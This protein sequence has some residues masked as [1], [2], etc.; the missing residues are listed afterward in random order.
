[1][2]RPTPFI[3]PT[4]CEFCSKKPA[5]GKTLLRCGRCKMAWY[6]SGACQHIAWSKH[7]FE[8]SFRPTHLSEPIKLSKDMVLKLEQE[9]KETTA[10]VDRVLARWSQLDCALIDPKERED[11]GFAY[12]KDPYFTALLDYTFTPDFLF[13]DR[14]IPNDA[15][16]PDTRNRFRRLVCAL[17]CIELQVMIREMISVGGLAV[18]V[19]KVTAVMKLG[20]GRACAEKIVAQPRDLSEGEYHHIIEVHRIKNRILNHGQ[21]VETISAGNNLWILKERLLGEKGGA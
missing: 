1:M 9:E 12:L 7:S 16:D 8:C 2:S 6:C 5:P 11:F 18:T 19:E 10:L 4:L 17:A 21:R 20:W 15:S 14:R 3:P 13:T